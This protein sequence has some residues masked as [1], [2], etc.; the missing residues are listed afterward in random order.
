MDLLDAGAEK[1]P[2]STVEGVDPEVQQLYAQWKEGIT[3]AGWHPVPKFS[4]NRRP[5][6]LEAAA[7]FAL[8]EGTATSASACRADGRP[9]ES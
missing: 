7:G 6:A 8:A 9:H 5:R 1:L 2:W 3:A 4:G